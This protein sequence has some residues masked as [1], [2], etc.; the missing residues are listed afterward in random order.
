VGGLGDEGPDQI[1][2]RVGEEGEHGVGVPPM[3][4]RHAEGVD[5]RRRQFDRPVTQRVGEQAAVCE[6]WGGEGEES[7]LTRLLE[8]PSPD[9]ARRTVDARFANDGSD[10]LSGHG[11]VGSVRP[12]VASS[13]RNRVRNLGGSGSGDGSARPLTPTQLDDVVLL[14]AK[15]RHIGL[16]S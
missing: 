13:V 10:M 2:Y 7:E 4:G 9:P 5:L 1:R 12:E 3:A 15:L 11:K 16:G 14:I 8:A 6:E